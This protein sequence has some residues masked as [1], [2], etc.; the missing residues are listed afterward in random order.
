MVKSSSSE[1]DEECGDKY[2]PEFAT[3]EGIE[4]TFT[5]VGNKITVTVNGKTI[6]FT[7]TDAVGLGT[8]T[9]SQTEVSASSHGYFATGTVFGLV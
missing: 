9:C 2:N 8:I 4:G 3:N 7:F 1:H 5:V 6:S